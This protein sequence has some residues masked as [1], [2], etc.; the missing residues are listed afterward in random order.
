MDTLLDVRRSVGVD[1]PVFRQPPTPNANRNNPTPRS[2]PPPAPAQ[3][4]NESAR[5]ATAVQALR[6]EF[7]SRF[8][9]LENNPFGILEH[10]EY[11]DD[12]QT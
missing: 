1:D 8:D 6:D 4:P 5:L 7:S 3:S 9:S 11:D 2:S 10:A 12:Q